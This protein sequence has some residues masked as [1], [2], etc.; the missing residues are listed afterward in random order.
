MTVAVW[1]RGESPRMIMV[2]LLLL[3]R[4]KVVIEWDGIGVGRSIDGD[5]GGWQQ[6][7][8]IVYVP[9]IVSVVLFFVTSNKKIRTF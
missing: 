5:G 9:H 6:H 8:S 1:W 3:A 2:T 4:E 7:R